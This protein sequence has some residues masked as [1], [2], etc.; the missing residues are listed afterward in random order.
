MASTGDASAPKGSDPVNVQGWAVTAIKTSV[1][2]IVT[3]L[4]EELSRGREAY[5]KRASC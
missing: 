4:F 2:L 1:L 5:M 3:A